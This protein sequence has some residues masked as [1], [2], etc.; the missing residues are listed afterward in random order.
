MKL[1]WQGR[2]ADT[3]ELERTGILSICG[4]LMQLQLRWIGHLDTD[5]LERTGMRSIY[6]I[7]RQ[8]QLRWSGHLMRMDDERLPKRLLYGDVATGSHRQGGQVRRYKDTLKTSLK[9]LQINLANW[10]DLFRDRPTDLDEDTEDSRSD[11]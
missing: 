4:V 1:R 2:I 6:A 10:K 5:V 8:M 7:L 11:L 3:D 9:R